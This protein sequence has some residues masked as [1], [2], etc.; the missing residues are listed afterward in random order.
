MLRPNQIK[1]INESISNDFDSGIHYHATGSGKSWI[2]MH[3]ILEYYMKY[4]TQNIIWI[5]EKNLF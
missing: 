5:C 3:I 4:P 1:A 2:A